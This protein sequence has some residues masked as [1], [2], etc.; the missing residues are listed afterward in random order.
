MLS[1]ANFPGANLLLQF[2]GCTGAC[3]SNTPFFRGF[4]ELD[5]STVPLSDPR[6]GSSFMVLDLAAQTARGNVPGGL[7]I[8][9]D[10]DIATGSYLVRSSVAPPVANAGPDQTVNEGTL[11]TLDGSGSIASQGGALSFS[12]TQLAG[13]PITLS[14]SNSSMP[15]FT[16]PFVSVGGET[17]TFQLIV[18]EDSRSSEPDI[19]NIHVVNVNK[20]PVA[21]AGPDQAVQEGSPVTLDGFGSFDE[22][23]DPLTFSWVQTA[24]SPVLLNNANTANPSFT[25]PLVGVAGDTLTF[26]LTV[27]DG[28]DSAMDSVSVF[29]ENVNH[30]PIANAGP[31]QTKDEG[32]AV[33]L[34]GAGSSDPDSDPFTYQW[35]QLFGSP[36]T[37]SDATSPNPTFTA[38]Q[39]GAGGETLVFSL[40]VNDGLANS[41][42]PDEVNI[43]VQ[44]INDP[45]ACNLARANPDVL[46]PPNHKLVS[47]GI[48][49]VTDPNNDTAQISITSVTQDEPVNGLGDGD[50][51]PDAVLQGDKVL[52]RVERAGTGNG[53]VY[54]I[55]FSANDGQGGNCTGQVSVGVPH[56]MKPGNSAVDDGQMYNS[57]LP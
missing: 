50:T 43:N 25:A 3:G 34:N 57:T 18:T 5:G 29:V 36:V 10:H 30:L 20:I 39:V 56:S 13:T 46:W 48:V 4:V 17:L 32:S 40:V 41:E 7:G 33:S 51:S 54:R 45:P 21:D 55:T 6:T 2:M 9:D 14:N 1:P 23:A 16:A 26:E 8:K 28:F 24:G 35:T 42:V 53:R 22:D 47:V 49:G 27:S 52:L 15:T 12:W 31:D 44:N 19:V 38:P 37:L 11:V